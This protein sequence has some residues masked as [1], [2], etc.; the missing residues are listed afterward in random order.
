ML[1]LLCAYRGTEHSLGSTNF[2][3][4]L[5]GL[6]FLLEPR[7]LHNLIHAREEMS[8]ISWLK[9]TCCLPNCPMATVGSR[10]QQGRSRILDSFPTPICPFPRAHG[11]CY[12]ST[13]E[14]ST[15]TIRTRK[16][17]W[18]VRER[19]PLHY[20]PPRPTAAALCVPF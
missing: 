10:T 11:L 6:L 17:D 1:V 3:S 8:A 7:I 12:P 13:T 14:H 18:A 19:P 2:H 4:E 16:T 20:S 5:L 9:V 15:F